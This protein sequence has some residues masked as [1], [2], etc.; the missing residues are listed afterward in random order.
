MQ[1]SLLQWYGQEYRKTKG[2]YCKYPF[3]TTLSSLTVFHAWKRLFT[4]L[5]P[6]EWPMHIHDMLSY[7]QLSFHQ[8]IP[9]GWLGIDLFSWC[10][11]DI[12]R[13]S[14]LLQY[15][16][17]TREQL[18]WSWYH[19]TKVTHTFFIVNPPLQSIR[20]IVDRE[21]SWPHVMDNISW[22]S[23]RYMSGFWWIVPKTN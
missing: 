9:A 11:L 10:N 18:T 12:F 16:S 20:H 6:S 1:N 8:Q 19:Q 23:S 7:D 15:R 21:T 17:S 5:P 14:I 3:G 2:V 22:S 13:Q 4:V